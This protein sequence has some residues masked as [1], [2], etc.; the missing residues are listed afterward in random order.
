MKFHFVKVRELPGYRW[1]PILVGYHYYESWQDAALRHIEMQSDQYDVVHHVVWSSLHLGSSLWRLPA[2]LVFG[3]IGGG[4]TSPTNYLR[5]FG[6]DSPTEALRTLVTRSSM[7]KLHSR[8][9]ETVRNAAV[10]LVTNSA[11]AAAARRLGATDVR[12]LVD[13]GLSA[14]WLIE[15]PRSQ[16]TGT[17]VVLWLG[18]LLPRKAPTLAVQ[19]FAQLRRIMPA[20]LVIAGDG[21]L[22]GQVCK[23]IARCGV[24]DDV[25]LLGQ[26]PWK[27]IAGLYESASVFLFT[28]LRDSF[29]S[30]FQEAMGKGLPTVAL[31]HNGIGDLDVGGAAI[32][33]AVS[34]E[35]RDLPGHLASAIQT[36][37]CDGKWESRSA[38]GVRLAGEWTFPAKAA[39]ATQIYKE[40]V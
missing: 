5:Y 27:E 4:Q 28:S 26:V 35:P 20:R 12:Y 2:P 22:R 39:A 13:G 3:P 23:E 9:R 29:G 38:A 17:P 32:K 8:S 33:V 11:T 25:Q 24:A 31:D 37:L 36:I 16:P 34:P 10:T 18:R 14:S 7:L 19:A 6:R 1:A 40:I 30:Q 21:P 15:E